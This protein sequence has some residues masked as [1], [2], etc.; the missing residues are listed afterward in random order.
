[1]STSRKNFKCVVVGDGA[2][3]KS[4]LIYMFTYN[5]FPTDYVPTVFD[6]CNASVEIDNVTYDLG[7]WDTAG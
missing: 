3:G 2:V 7:I 4:S 6:N 1:M 5:S